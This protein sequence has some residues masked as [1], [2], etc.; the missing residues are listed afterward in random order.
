VILVELHSRFTALIKV[1][2]KRHGCCRLRIEP[3]RPPASG[4][5]AALVDLGPRAEYP[6]RRP[7][8][9]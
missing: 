1:A 5:A 8:L 9:H 7:G 4:D 2:S 3:A 6:I